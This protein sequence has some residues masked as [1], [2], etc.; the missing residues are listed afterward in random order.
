MSSSNDYRARE[1]AKSRRRNNELKKRSEEISRRLR[2]M[3]QEERNKICRDVAAAKLQKDVRRREKEI[4]QLFS[5]AKSD[6]ALIEK[7]KRG[8][9]DMDHL[10]MLVDDETTAEILG[11]ES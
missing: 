3:P 7:I 5:A 8:E 2:E 9:V 1:A 4:A 6:M 10:L 11:L